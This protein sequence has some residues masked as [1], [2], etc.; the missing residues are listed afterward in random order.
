MVIEISCIT[1]VEE[2]RLKD[3]P[4]PC[5][6]PMLAEDI[7]WVELT[8]KVMECHDLGCNGLMHPMEGE[9]I[10]VL[11]KLGMGNGGA[12]NHGLVV[13]KHVALVPNRNSKVAEH[14]M[15]VNSLVNT[16]AASNKFGA[17]GSRLNSGLLLGVPVDSSLVEKV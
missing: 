15:K 6:T 16:G 4:D 7:S 14:V 9:S 1:R 17:I 10:V 2:K 5:I 12:I 13:T 11:M 8:R 3:P